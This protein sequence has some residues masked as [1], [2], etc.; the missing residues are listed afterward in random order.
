MDRIGMSMQVGN[1]TVNLSNKWATELA[2]IRD[3]ASPSSTPTAEEEKLVRMVQEDDDAELL[4]RFNAA[5]TIGNEYEDGQVG[6]RTERRITR[7]VTKAEAERQ[8]Q[9]QQEESK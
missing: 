4:A 9:E 6:P 8:Q 3:S 5:V 1:R 2:A 7:S